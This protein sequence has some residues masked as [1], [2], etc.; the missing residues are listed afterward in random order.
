VSSDNLDL[1]RRHYEDWNNGDTDSV[2]AAFAPDVEWHGH[3]RLPEPGP[4]TRRDDVER[5]MG[6][7]R[8]AWGELSADPV[9]LIDAGA[10][11]VV[12][13][14]HMTGRGRG[15][16]VEVQGGVDVHVITLGAE[17][18]TYFQIHPADIAADRAGLSDRE[19]D[20]LV[21]RVASGLPPG[22]IAD[23]L[24]A[25]EDDIQEILAAAFEKLRG[26]PVKETT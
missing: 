9:E 21:L 12:A 20:V 7:F 10:G 16:G 4:Y 13:L 14:V 22:A 11:G 23:R 8:E 3:P 18:I 15:S 26:L 24:D 25:D 19:M 5:W 17:G 1:V 6:Q 2:I